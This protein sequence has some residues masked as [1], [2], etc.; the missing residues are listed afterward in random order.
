MEDDKQ[1]VSVPLIIVSN[2]PS[3]AHNKTSSSSQW[4][5]IFIMNLNVY[6]Y[7]HDFVLLNQDQVI[8]SVT[9]WEIYCDLFKSRLISSVGSLGTRKL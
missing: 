1:I 8:V 3:F 4:K 2:L 7:D 9:L 5:G 6:L